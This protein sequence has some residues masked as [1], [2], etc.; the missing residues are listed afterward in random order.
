MSELVNTPDLF[1]HTDMLDATPKMVSETSNT[2]TQTGG[3][4][5]KDLSDYLKTA[6]ISDATKKVYINDYNRLRALIGNDKNLYNISQ[7][8]ILNAIKSSENAQQNLL[9]IAIVI[10]RGKDKPSSKLVAYREKIINERKEY[11]NEK[12]NKILK[13]SGLSFE[14]LNDVLNKAVGNDYMLAY[15]LINFNVRN[16]DLVIKISSRDNIKSIYNKNDNFM[17]VYPNKVVYIRQ[18]YKTKDFYGTKKHIIKD[19]KFVGTLKNRLLEGFDYA[20]TTKFKDKPLTT[21]EMQYY[22]NRIFKKYIPDLQNISQS[23]IYKI[24]Q[25]HYQELGDIK[26]LQEIAQLRGHRINTQLEEYSS[27]L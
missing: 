14:A 13:K 1:I 18:D 19:K 21:Q 24:I 12:N 23:I 3:K 25:N 5:N 26:K 22:I 2:I 15:L 9:N 6:T 8:D 20:F 16:N 4:L 17:V 10:L 11:Q 7:K 27:T